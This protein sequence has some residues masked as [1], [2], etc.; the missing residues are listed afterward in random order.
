ME[1]L[2]G[3][4]RIQTFLRR[5]YIYSYAQG[6]VLN[7]LLLAEDSMQLNGHLPDS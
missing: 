3:K 2:A 6:K 1:T 7:F 4:R 5:A